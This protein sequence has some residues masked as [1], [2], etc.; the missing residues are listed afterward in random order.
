MFAGTLVDRI[1]EGKRTLGH[2]ERGTTTYGETSVISPCLVSLSDY[3]RGWTDGNRSGQAKK[4]FAAL[5][6][7]VYL[8]Y[9]A[10]SPSAACRSG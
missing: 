6:D 7:T 10:F 2:N 8:E 1:T 3:C 4:A 5:G 9:Q